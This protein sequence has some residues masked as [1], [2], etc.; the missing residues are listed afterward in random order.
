MCCRS[1]VGGL[2]PRLFPQSGRCHGPEKLLFNKAES[3]R[4]CNYGWNRRE[5]LISAFWCVNRTFFS[6]EAGFAV[7][8]G[9]ELHKLIIALVTA[10]VVKNC[11]ILLIATPAT[12]DRTFKGD[13]RAGVQASSQPIVRPD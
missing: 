4:N 3:G 10:K 12:V 6:F 13:S 11:W 1:A 8:V 5:S 2:A 7:R 9:F